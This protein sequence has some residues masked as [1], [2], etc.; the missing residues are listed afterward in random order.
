MFY[1]LCGTRYGTDE[2][3]LHEELERIKDGLGDREA[4]ASNT[5][6]F[7]GKQVGFNQLMDACMAM[8]FLGTHRLV[9]VEGLLG[10]FSG[11]EEEG[12]VE[13]E[14]KKKGK[15]DIG[16]WK[17]LKERVGEMAPTT[18]LVLIEG[19]VNRN[20]ALFKAIAPLA[21]VKQFSFLS[22]KALEN[23]IR[24]RVGQGGGKI[25]LGAV[26]LLAELVGQNLWMLASEIDKLLLYTEG[27]PI[28]EEDV[29]GVVSYAKEANVFT[30][31]DALV[32]GHAARAASLLHRSL[33]EGDTAPYLLVMITRQ[34]RLLVQAKELSLQ[35]CK[36]PEIKS[37]L[38][39]VNDF[40]L[41]KALEQG[42]HYTMER[43]E[44]VYH[45]LVETDVAIKRG[46]LK[47]D[48]ALDLLVAELCE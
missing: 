46:W 1:I 9:I 43:L 5:T 33:D 12:G 23:W 16:E 28:E 13:G 32:D 10:R 18:V 3:S 24:G 15:K 40:V 22:G 37:R 34:L 41:N 30:M 6:V 19:D 26:K 44:Q 36:Y 20:S 47:G 29:R 27:R 17:G 48:M 42:R 4:L 25:S 2:F 11:G 39:V 45:K 7:D 14:V 38:G 35:H 31:V 8:P 21:Q